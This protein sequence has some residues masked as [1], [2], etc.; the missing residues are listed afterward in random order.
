MTHGKL[1]VSTSSEDLWLENILELGWQLYGYV[2][3]LL[4]A[5]EV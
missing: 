3:A 1:I 4:N 2:I 5:N